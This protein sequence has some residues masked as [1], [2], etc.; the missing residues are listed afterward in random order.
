MSERLL[1]HFVQLVWEATHKSFWRRQG[2]RD[3]LRRCGVKDSLLA[4][5]AEDESK[6]E[7]LNR[8]FPGLESSDA[9]ILTIYR[10]ADSLTEQ[11][12]FPDLDGWD[13]ST[14]MKEEAARAVSSL[15]LYLS[16]QREAAANEREKTES[17]RRAAEYREQQLRQ[18]QD[19]GKLSDRLTALAPKQGT[20]PGGYAFQDWFYDL[21]EYFELTH[22]RPYNI[23][24][25]QIDGSVTVVNTTY[26][27]ELKFV[28]ESVGA[29]DVDVFRRKVESKADNTMGI[30][31]SMSGYTD[32]GKQAAGGERSPILLLNCQH[33][34]AVLGGALKLDELI[35]SVR[36][37]ASQTGKA[38]FEFNELS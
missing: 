24:G 3:F 34:Y 8:L 29:P 16:N 27:V 31:V 26:L 30:M 7:F 23:D 36:R 33:L 6:R 14:R 37:H 12:S 17:R 13:E 25:R 35:A 1:P 32:P 4:T 28:L 5:W 20:A 15:K 11:V 10:I 21:V 38:Y 18:Q 22:R 19:L 9:G 2:L